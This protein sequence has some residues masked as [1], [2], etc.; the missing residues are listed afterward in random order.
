[1]PV[2]SPDARV[3]ITSA[4]PAAGEEE[5]P[6]VVVID[7]SATQ[8]A[9]VAAALGDHYE[10]RAFADAESAL[11]AI[12]ALPPSVVVS[13]HHLPGKCGLEVLAELR[14]DVVL[15]RIPFIL[16]IA[17]ENA[18][19][20]SMEAGAA[21]FLTKPVAAEELRARVAAA[22]RS[23]RMILELERKHRELVIAHLESKRLERELHQAQKLEAV[24]RLASG[25]AHEIN[26]PIQFIGDNT[27]FL[28]DACRGLLAALE[29]Q[30]EALSQHAPPEV[31]ARLED[32]VQR[33]DLPFVVEQVPRTIARTLEGVRRVASIV[34]AMKEFAHP[35]QKEM[36]PTD[37]NH[38]LR[39]TL[40]VARNEYKY[41]ADV[42]TELG[43]M[44]L[45]TCHAGEVNQVFL[46]ILV[47][48]A[49]AIADRVG[50]TGERGRIRVATSG[51]GDAV[52]IAISDTGSGIPEQVRPKIFEPFF[53][54]KEVGRG[55]GQGL[56]IARSVVEKHRGDIWFETMVGEGTTFHLR[57]PV[58][59]GAAERGAEAA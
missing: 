53:T 1:M 31:R 50:A 4:H 29:E 23:C 7:D 18:A 10:I 38:A 30:R 13:D 25:I 6:G 39:A 9:L 36:V 42:V 33:L 2:E 35:D 28:E 32:A 19:L 16:L 15:Q 45:V 41:V 8:R 57:L 22:L 46:N 52:W 43:D 48:A 44:P 56:A 17:E 51:H 37:L 34:K 54:T 26:T 47:N 12:R 5:R 59:P 11:A 20:R 14:E 27:R 3:A 49:H 40:E 24:G 58:D 21:D 55:T